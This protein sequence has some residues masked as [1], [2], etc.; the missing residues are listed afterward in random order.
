MSDYDPTLDRSFW[1]IADKL[2]TPVRT[3]FALGDVLVQLSQKGPQT[4]RYPL[5]GNCPVVFVRYLRGDET[6]SRIDSNGMAFMYDALVGV[7]VY[8]RDGRL[9]LNAV[10]LSSFVKVGHLPV[11]ELLALRIS[12]S[13]DDF[14]LTK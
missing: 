8:R 4:Y 12:A 13:G 1:A 2:A 10:T 6:V 11:A 9:L 3:D 14:G 5:C 7:G